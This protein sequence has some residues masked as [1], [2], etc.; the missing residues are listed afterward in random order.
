MESGL[1]LIITDV[2][3]VTAQM[4]K[5]EQDCVGVFKDI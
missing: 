1:E 4:I 3:D 2:Y 5:R